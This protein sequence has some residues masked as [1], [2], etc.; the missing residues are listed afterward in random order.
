M[1][2]CCV[3]VMTMLIIAV[4]SYLVNQKMEDIVDGNETTIFIS[5][6]QEIRDAV[7]NYGHK[8]MIVLVSRLQDGDPYY[9]FTI[10]YQ[11]MIEIFRHLDVVYVV[12]TA[13]ITEDSTLMGPAITHIPD[14]SIFILDGQP[15]QYDICSLQ[16]FRSWGKHSP[17]VVFHTDQELVWEDFPDAVGTYANQSACF[18]S[19]MVHVYKEY[20]YVFRTN[21]YS[22]LVDQS[23]VTF[24]PL[25]PVAA[26]YTREFAEAHLPMVKASER[27][28]WCLFS[29]R[30]SY[31]Y[32]TKYHAERGDL[33]LNITH[34][35]AAHS[36][37][38]DHRQCTMLYSEPNMYGHSINHDE[39][40][41]TLSQTAFAPCPA[42]NNPET[43]RH[44]E[45]CTSRIFRIRKLGRVIMKITPC[46]LQFQAMALGAIPILVKN[47]FSTE[48]DF[49]RGVH[50]ILSH[51]FHIINYNISAF[52]YVD[53]VGFPVPIFGSWTE[54]LA[55][56]HDIS[57]R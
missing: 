55:F 19:N 31:G 41:M 15:G 23:H 50:F 7:A 45:V 21:Y 6:I 13:D 57:N 24:V 26:R 12:L 39:Y 56:V 46:T 36:A 48:E 53:W 54:A 40:L 18:N 37:V 9:L 34:L 52:E 4:N 42:G 33:I 30:L 44:Y 8:L 11:R 32:R 47:M 10:N 25:G 17:P 38:H 3:I 14:N 5:R 49:T 22:P 29:G 20:K 16:T 27:L 2:A 28:M 43:F 35:E 51:Y 1:A